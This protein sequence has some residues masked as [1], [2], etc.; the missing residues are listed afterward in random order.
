ML[1]IVIAI[2]VLLLVL[3]IIWQFPIGEPWK[4]IVMAIVVLA[5]LIWI[6]QGGGL[7]TLNLRN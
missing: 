3:F 6:L 1:S 7:G 5:F 4:T 2:L